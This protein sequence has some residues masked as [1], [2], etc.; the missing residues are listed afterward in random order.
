M[1][2]QAQHRRHPVMRASQR[3]W[4][5]PAG[6]CES[7]DRHRQQA[8]GVGELARRTA[9]VSAIGKQ[10]IGKFLIEQ[11]EP[12]GNALLAAHEANA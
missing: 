11:S 9:D 5:L 8:I 12:D 2:K 10:L 1:A 7:V 6:R 4:Y 3:L